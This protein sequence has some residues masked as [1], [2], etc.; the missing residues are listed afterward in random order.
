[1]EEVT[2]TETRVLVEETPRLPEVK[3]ERVVLYHGSGVRGIKNFGASE[4]T[5]IGQGLYLTSD[6]QSAEGYARRRI[7]REKDGTST[8]YE[9]EVANLRLADLRRPEALQVFAGALEKRLEEELEK[10]S[11]P[12]YQETAIR[13]TLGKIKNKSYHS[14]K[15]LVWHHQEIGTE[16]VKDM[17]FDGLVAIEGGEGEEI[18]EHDSYVI[19]DPRKVRILKEKEV[20]F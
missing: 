15:D 20:S 13:E 16:I 19:F 1:M 9:A 3:I 2:E 4:E 14:L 7:K 5:T 17:G 12:W 18:K 11:F 6:P 8:V 10:S